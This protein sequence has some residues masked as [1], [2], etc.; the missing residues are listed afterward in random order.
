MDKKK[1]IESLIEFIAESESFLK[2][3]DTLSSDIQTV[4]SR[5]FNDDMADEDLRLA[6]GGK[7]EP[8]KIQ[9]S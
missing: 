4:F 1:D 9:K 6:A 3:Q 5:F 7:S 8:R 2:G